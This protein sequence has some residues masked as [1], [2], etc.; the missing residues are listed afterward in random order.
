M[1]I[2][3]PTTRAHAPPQWRCTQCGAALGPLSGEV[4]AC[5][6]C[7]REF[8][9]EEGILRA[10]GAL[11][12]R[13]R[14]AEAFYNGPRFERFRFWENLFLSYAGGRKGARLQILRHLPQEPDGW[15]LEVGI[16]DGDNLPLLPE[17][18]QMAGVDIARQRLR[19]C[20]N[21]H[22]GR[23][24]VLALAEAEWLPFADGSF[25]AV[26]SV[27]GFNFYS[28]PARSLSEMVRV[29]RPRGT[30]VVADEIPDFVRYGWGHRLRVPALDRW[31]MDRWFGREFREMVFQN[32]WTLGSIERLGRR[33]LEEAELHR[34]WR[35]YGYCLTGRAPQAD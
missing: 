3:T 12:G 13:N 16:G 33:W 29:A 15:W 2:S 8:E 10:M 17:G 5:A 1:T 23:A 34:I 6:A 31:L 24:P 22:A 7:G 32:E 21:A 18:A 30:I 20:R 11:S 28:D 25:Q 9:R 27:G 19:R 4:V 26:F 35:G 14:I